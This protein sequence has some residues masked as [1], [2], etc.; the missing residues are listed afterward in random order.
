M[1]KEEDKESELERFLSLSFDNSAEGPLWR[2]RLFPAHPSGPCSKQELKEKFPHQF[3]LLLTFHHGIV[4][5]VSAMAMIRLILTLLDAVGQGVHVNQ[6][7]IGRAVSEQKTMDMEK[8]VL[9]ELQNRPQEFQSMIDE[10]A[11]RIFNP[12]ITQA[13]G[14]P[15][16]EKWPTSFLTVDLEP[17]MLHAFHDRCQSLGLT[18]NSGMTSVINTA[19][20]ELVAEAGLEGDV[21]SVTSRHAVD[22]RRYWKGDPFKAFGNHMG[23]MSHSMETPRHNRIHFWEYAKQFDQEF[24]RKLKD[25]YI[26][27]ERI[28]R[29]RILP[30][31][32]THEAFYSSRPPTV[33][34]Y[35]FSNVY[36]KN[37][38]NHDKESLVQMTDMKHYSNISHCEYPMIYMLSGFNE[39]VTLTLMYD[40]GRVSRN[41][42]KAFID[43]VKNVLQYLA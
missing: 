28:V 7:P 33:Y 35:F 31:D 24:R 36:K 23:A 30:E 39:P 17:R 10:A 27:Q 18:L 8:E 20:V 16:K 14:T 43:K 40:T 32:Y 34:D 21:F 22:Q 26:F 9:R 13:F 11:R 25:G 38:L 12:L 2:A 4:D 3:D 41:T 5:G 37:F 29:S 42:A 19:L 6:E 1:L 15:Q